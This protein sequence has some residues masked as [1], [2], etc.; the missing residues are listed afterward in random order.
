[1]P[2]RLPAPAL[3]LTLAACTWVSEEDTKA[4]LDVDED[5]VPWPEDCDDADPNAYPGAPETCGDDLLLDCDLSEAEAEARCQFTGDSSSSDADAVLSGSE[6]KGLAGYDIAHG[7]M[8]GDGVGELV[9]GAPGVEDKR[10]A[11]YVVSAAQPTSGELASL[12]LLLSGP[13]AETGALPGMVGY[14]VTEPRDLDGDGFGDLVLGAPERE[15]FLSVVDGEGTTCGPG[16][17]LLVLGPPAAMDLAL[18]DDVVKDEGSALCLGYS[19]FAAGDLDADGYEDVAVGAPSRESPEIEPAVLVLSW[20]APGGEHAANTRRLVGDAGSLAGAGLAAGDLSGDGQPD[21]VIGAYGGDSAVYV[22]AGQE[23]REDI[24][25]IPDRALASTLQTESGTNYGATL[26][27]EDV[28]GDGAADL[29]VGADRDDRYRTDGGGVYLFL[30]PLD[31]AVSAQAAQATLYCDSASCRLGR[32]IA[33][34]DLDQDGAHDLIA[35]APGGDVDSS[36]GGTVALLFGAEDLEGS[37]RAGAQDTARAGLILGSSGELLG[38]GVG[39][40]ADLGGE[41]WVWTGAVGSGGATVAGGALFFSGWQ[42][43]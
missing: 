41:A 8:D 30:G 10:G 37:Q 13:A 38:F 16:S 6:S 40:S 24:A 34:V 15:S 19:V 1:M 27:V 4:R 18:A 17:A 28:N 31:G 21:L 5:A 3:L 42:T 22:V 39:G 36:T 2:P 29:A 7:D 25:F 26:A 11:V 35:G 9:I 33:L 20:G 43:W 23:T 14:A 12:G 32:S